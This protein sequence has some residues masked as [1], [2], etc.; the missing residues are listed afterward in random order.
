[1]P[2]PTPT[3]ER[4]GFRSSNPPT[5]WSTC[6]ASQLLVLTLL[7]CL[8][9]L[10]ERAVDAQLFNFKK[11]RFQQPAVPVAY[12]KA[13]SK[14]SLIGDLNA[15][16]TRVRQLSASATI[17]VKDVPSKIRGTLQV[18]LPDRMRLKAGLMGVSELGIDAGSNSS[19][20][21]I[22]S[23]F[24]LP[25]QPPAMYF[26]SHEE[27]Q[28]SRI[29]QQLPIEPQWL[30]DA[31]GL[32]GLDP[33]GQHV[34]PFETQQ[35]GWMELY[36]VLQ[37]PG[38][39]KQYRKLLIGSRTGLVEQTT[40][41]DARKNVIAYANA[42]RFRYFEEFEI[43]LPQRIDFFVPDGNGQ[44]TTMLEVELSSYSINS[45]FGDPQKMWSRPEAA[46]SQQVNLG[47]Q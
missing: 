32:V 47:R 7:V 33:Q 30:I 24:P 5:G 27:F 31:I 14:L 18:E 19:E 12:E 39:E 46:G 8:G 3:I 23:K 21:W 26:A 9:L 10:P 34:G 28:K 29:R 17:K 43:S 36:S 6:R 1:M 11:F 22:W 41:Y 38:G 16:V 37:T 35:P 13:P 44:Y 15:R 25:N 45:L 4:R 42:S 40:I 20:F 2:L